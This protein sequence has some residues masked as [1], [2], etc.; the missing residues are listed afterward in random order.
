[1]ICHSPS[2]L[3]PLW[4]ILVFVSFLHVEGQKIDLDSK[5][6]DIFKVKQGTNGGGC[7]NYPV[8]DWFQDAKLLAG[9]ARNAVLVA[10]GV[11]TP[12]EADLTITKVDAQQ[13]L[14]AFFNIAPGGDEDLLDDIIN[15]VE[16]FMISVGDLDQETKPEEDKPW[17]FCSSDWLERKQWEDTYEG[18]NRDAGGEEKTIK[19]AYLDASSKSVQETEAELKPYV[20]WWSADIGDYLLDGRSNYC[21]RVGAVASTQEQ[22]SPASITLCPRRWESQPETLS[23]IAKVTKDGQSLGKLQ[24]H[25]LTLF[26]EMFHLVLGNDDTP[27]HTYEIDVIVADENHRARARLRDTDASK[28][29]YLTAYESAH[30]PETWVF[31]ALA[32]HLMQANPDYSFVTSKS[33]KRSE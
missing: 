11:K 29:G 24:V 13:L 25:S 5:V 33:Q 3:S 15:E 26:H 10:G 31:F 7:D 14:L 28:R 22:I 2:V 18:P 20:P 17:I 4:F 27:D 30:N 32:V 23:G 19:Q 6:T 8:E 1:M 12:D 21:S 9:F 16:S